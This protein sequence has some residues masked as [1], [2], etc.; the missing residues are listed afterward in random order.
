M[1]PRPLRWRLPPD[2]RCARFRY[3]SACHGTGRCAR[4]CRPRSDARACP[5]APSCWEGRNLSARL[6][7]RRRT[8]GGLDRLV[9]GAACR[10]RRTLGERRNRPCFPAERSPGARSGVR[11]PQ[12]FETC[13]L[14]DFRHGARRLIMR[15]KPAHHVLFQVLLSKKPNRGCCATT[16][17]GGATRF[18]TI[19][20]FR[21]SFAS[22]FFGSGGTNCANTSRTRVFAETS[23]TIVGAGAGTTASAF[24]V[25]AGTIVGM[26]VSKT[27]RSGHFRSEWI[28]MTDLSTPVLVL[29]ASATGN[30]GR[31]PSTTNRSASNTPP[32]NRK[33][34]A[35]G[36][37][38][39]LHP[40]QCAD[41]SN[42]WGWRDWF[43]VLRA[44]DND[45]VTAS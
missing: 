25:C 18:F 40:L 34:R 2:R 36:I 3:W 10:R 12:H 24:A 15:D 35:K 22:G 30:V 6:R 39:S 4:K 27:T 43:L 23:A 8:L 44:Q 42:N 33:Y 7:A 26:L 37:S 5:T 31:A 20:R 1:T 32:T 13:R 9:R 19:L 28:L 29:S 38:A 17:I 14:D 21:C 41:H 45:E 11:Q 16:T